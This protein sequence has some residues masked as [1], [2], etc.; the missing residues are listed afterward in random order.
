M[1]TRN[2]KKRD[3]LEMTNRERTRFIKEIKEKLRQKVIESK[4]QQMLLEAENVT[5]NGNVV[6]DE[7]Q[8]L[9]GFC[10]DRI[11]SNPHFYSLE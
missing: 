9:S 3:L 11:R 5:V 10:L 8:P 2:K 4:L 1:F 7:N 6:Y